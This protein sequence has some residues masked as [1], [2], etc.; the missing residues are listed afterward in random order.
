MRLTE[1][2]KG[3]QSVPQKH[4][5]KQKCGEACKQE[6]PTSGQR[7][8]NEWSSK[9]ENKNQEDVCNHSELEKSLGV[10]AGIFSLTSARI[11]GKN[12]SAFKKS[13]LE[14]PTCRLAAG[15]DLRSGVRSVMVFGW[16]S[17]NY[18]CFKDCWNFISKYRSADVGL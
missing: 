4:E 3:S 5:G 12:N 16:L 11:Q 7:R 2:F 8:E 15:W 14:E 9:T 13:C 1:S 18:A 10:H 6:G 17:E